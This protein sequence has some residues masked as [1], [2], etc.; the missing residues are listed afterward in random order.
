[1]NREILFKAKRKLNGKWVFGSLISIGNDWCQIITANTEYDDIS[2]SMSRVITDTV[3]QFTGL[4]DKNGTK[5][6]EGDIVKVDIFTKNY[7]IVF[8]ESEKWGASFQYKSDYSIY[9]LTENFAK[10]CVVV[11]N[12]YENPELL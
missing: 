7:C 10:D 1:M 4:T 3:C 6:F 5:I 9:Y 11:G 12:I 2:Q 8:G